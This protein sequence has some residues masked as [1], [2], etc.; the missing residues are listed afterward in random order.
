M[1]PLDS[2]HLSEETIHANPIEYGCA[3]I[4]FKPLEDTNGILKCQ[5]S[6]EL[7]M[8]DFVKQEDIEAFNTFAGSRDYDPASGLKNL[9]N[10]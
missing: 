10:N 3:H 5:T 6:Q 8:L 2:L 9:V 1:F 7:K 4:S